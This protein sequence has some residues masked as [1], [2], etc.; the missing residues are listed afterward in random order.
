MASDLLRIL[1]HGQ[2]ISDT[3]DTR[4]HA[5]EGGF[6]TSSRHPS[7]IRFYGGSSSRSGLNS[8]RSS[9]YDINTS[10][11]REGGSG[12]SVSPDIQ[13]TASA[14]T[15]RESGLNDLSDPYHKS[16]GHGD[17]AH[18]LRGQRGHNTNGSPRTSDHY[19]GYQEADSS[20]SPVVRPASP[21]R[22]G[23]LLSG[24]GTERDNGPAS[25]IHPIVVTCVWDQVA[26]ILFVTGSCI[27]VRF[28]LHDLIM[29]GSPPLLVMIR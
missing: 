21:A 7:G 25:T 20:C 6:D 4:C 11:R 29:M 12:G 1:F 26:L 5:R 3:S 13:R 9:E 2:S 27:L 28:H 14:G 22:S 19:Y 23:N 24:H 17:S 16:Y 8:S 15:M 10:H 18:D